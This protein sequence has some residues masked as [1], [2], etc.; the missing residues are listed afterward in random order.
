MNSVDTG[1]VTDENPLWKADA[2]SKL[3]NF[4]A[5]LDEMEGASRVLDPIF[6]TLESG[7]PIF[8]KF[9]KDFQETEW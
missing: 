1:W 7:Q 4:M 9:L 8:G 6:C 5:P 2:H 3:V